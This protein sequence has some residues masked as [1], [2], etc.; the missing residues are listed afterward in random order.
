MSFWWR[1]REFGAGLL[2]RARQE[3]E[4]DEEMAFYLEQLTERYIQR[5]YSP[6]AARQAARRGFGSVEHWQEGSRRERGGRRLTG[7]LQDL[8]H[9]LRSLR[10]DPG[11]SIV[12]ILSLALGIGLNTAV[13]GVLKGVYLNPLP[14]P[15]PEAL[16]LIDEVSPQQGAG[17]VAY[18]NY[19]DWKEQNRTCAAMGAYHDS[20]I[21]ITDGPEPVRLRVARMTASLVE[22]LGV[23]P[24]LGRNLL[25]EDEEGSRNVWLSYPIWRNRYGE[26]RSVV[27]TTIDLD[28]EPYTVSGVM[29]PEF[30]LPSPRNLS[31]RFDLFLPFPDTFGE[32]ARI[33][34]GYQV[35]AR[36][37]DGV[38][39][40]TAREDLAG[41]AG[42]L[43]LQY[44]ESNEGRS[45]VLTSVHD[46]LFGESGRQILMIFA[47]AGLVLL[48]ACADIAALQTARTIPQRREYAIRSTLGADRG[49]I[50][51]QLLGESVLLALLGGAAAYGIAVTGT[52]VLKSLVPPGM[53]RS[54]D[55]RLDT[56]VFLFALVLTLLSAFFFGLVPALSAARLDPARIIKETHARGHS[57]SGRSWYRTAL[58]IG[59]FALSLL[60]ANTA[61]LLLQSYSALR[62]TDPGFQRRPVLTMAVSLST[63]RFPKFSDRTDFYRTLLPRIAGLSGVSSAGATVSLPL[64][65]EGPEFTVYAEPTRATDRVEEGPPAYV[66]AITGDCFAALGIP[67]ERGRPLTLDDMIRSG[68]FGVSGVVVNRTLAD[69][70]WPGADPVGKRMSLQADGS[71]WME[72]VGVV[73]DIRQRGFEQP[74]EPELFVPYSMFG[75]RRMLLIVQSDRPIPAL[76]SDIR[77]EIA[78]LDPTLPVSEVRTLE[79]VIAAQLTPRAFYTTLIGV[80]ACLALV[81]AALGIF[82]VVSYSVARRTRE[83]GIRLALGSQKHEVIGVVLRQVIRVAGFGLALGL[84]GILASSRILSGFVYAVRPLDGPTIAGA[85]L[86]L[87]LVGLAAALHP[88][89]RATRVSPLTAIREEV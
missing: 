66:T 56:P 81:L 52:T 23:P 72:V 59:Q 27:G 35:V 14:L 46:A 9:T 71:T 3:D 4:L 29:P 24:F 53:P 58:V 49:R 43:A 50:M 88:A 12:V 63:A 32:F 39:L 62:G 25:P 37:R 65:E 61:L 22:V 45:A 79:D 5:G 78:G 17:P 84:V 54:G 69:R 89:L 83:F 55:I 87:V 64:E 44:P 36:L 82:G 51:G 20:H 31:E 80:F 73:G 26:N 67:V 21:N 42:R 60:L 75:L 34:Y 70:L 28:G 8:R 16:F 11:F 57:P 1:L 13:F 76:L 30:T 40:Q 2:H 18:A 48:I 10:R 19:L 77:R 74:P 15:E 86:F 41:I 6:E 68:P 7:F 47:A 38:S 33:V 85:S